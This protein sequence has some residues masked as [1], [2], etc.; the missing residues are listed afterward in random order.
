LEAANSLQVP[1]ALILGQKEV[2]DGTIIIRDME[3]GVQEIVDQKKV[4][5]I[6]KKKLDRFDLSSK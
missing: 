2:Q 3:S 1:Y 6:L 5:S 4:E